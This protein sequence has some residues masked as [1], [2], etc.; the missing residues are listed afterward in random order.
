MNEAFF[1]LQELGFSEYEAKTYLSLLRESPA[2]AYEVGKSSGVPTSKVYEIL[3]KLV[4]KGILSVI[5]EGKTKKYVPIEPGELLDRY[6]T[7]TEKVVDNL[8]NRLATVKGQKELSYIWNIHE[9]EYLVDKAKRMIDGSGVSVLI[10][11]W[12]E[13]F[14]FLDDAIRDALQ[15]K[16]AVAV[17]HFGFPVLRLGQMYRHPIEDTIYQEK[18]GRGIVI[19][20]DSKEVLMGTVLKDNKVEGAWSMNRGFV[21]LA[22]DYIKHDVYMMKIVRRFHGPLRKRFGSTYEK[23]R[24]IFKDE[25]II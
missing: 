4:E 3:K 20:V 7:R 11:I 17:V 14:T 8:R 1:E 25:V 18:G 10:S 2:T 19:V 5:D 16:V 23:L 9:Y 15:R 21:T 13:E 24:D 6:K 12:K 22:E